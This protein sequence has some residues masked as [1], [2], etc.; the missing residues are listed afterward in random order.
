MPYN[1]G[2]ISDKG[3]N[4]KGILCLSEV[5]DSW[6]IRTPASDSSTITFNINLGEL[7]ES[8][9]DQVTSKTEYKNEAGVVKHTEFEYSL[10]TTGTLMERD[11]IKVDFLSH[12][13]K[14]KLYL[15]YKYAGIVDGKHQEYF[16][17]VQVTPQHSIKLPGGATSMKY[18]ST[19][20]FPDAAVTISSTNLA[21][22]ETALS[23]TIYCT[24]VAIPSAQGYCLK[25]T[26]VS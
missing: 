16:K 14:N 6:V 11:K 26:A 20:I 5:T 9:L 8:S 24:G 23:I 25:E 1:Q 21:A 13:C 22:I 15:E 19:G 18:E 4:K 2:A 3:R 7:S 12:G 17:M 10:N